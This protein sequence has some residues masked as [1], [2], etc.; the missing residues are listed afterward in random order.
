VS[1][2]SSRGVKGLEADFS[3]AKERGFVSWE[4][5]DLRSSHVYVES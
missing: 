1:K 4:Y 5:V 2:G 3:E